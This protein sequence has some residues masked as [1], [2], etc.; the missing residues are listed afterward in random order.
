MLEGQYREDSQGEGA[1]MWRGLVW[2]ACQETGGASMSRFVMATTVH[3]H[4]RG[5]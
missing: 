1:T 3:V 4:F 5:A 2:K